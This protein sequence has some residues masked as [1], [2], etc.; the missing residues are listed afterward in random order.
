MGQIEIIGTNRKFTDYKPQDIG[1]IITM[2]LDVGVYSLN[3]QSV[4]PA[5]S[6]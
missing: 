6:K 4:K 3:D 1:I 5:L 2:P